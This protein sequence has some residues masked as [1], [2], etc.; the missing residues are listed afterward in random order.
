M[1]GVPPNVRATR[2]VDYL[3][4]FIAPLWI[5]AR[6]VD[7]ELLRHADLSGTVKEHGHSVVWPVADIL[8][9]APV[10]VVR[11]HNTEAVR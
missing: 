2:A 3:S 5:A 11:V 7:M 10:V 4:E 6:R 8:P 9:V 1:R